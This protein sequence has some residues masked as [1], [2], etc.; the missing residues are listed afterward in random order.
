MTSNIKSTRLVLEGPV[1]DIVLSV[2]PEGKDHNPPYLVADNEKLD[3][4]KRP[5][6]WR[7]SGQFDDGHRMSPTKYLCLLLRSRIHEYE[8]TVGETFLILEP[9]LGTDSYRRLGSGNFPGES[10]IFDLT[11]RRILSFV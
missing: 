7:Y 10:Q 4:D 3:F 2:A 11:D 6:P 8:A 5:F 1:R 9:Y